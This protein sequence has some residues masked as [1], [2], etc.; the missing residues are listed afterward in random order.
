MD[1][2]GRADRPAALDGDRDIE[3]ERAVIIEEIRSYLD[4]P[5]EYC[6][7]LSRRRCSATG[8]S[9]AR[10]AATRRASGRCPST[11][12]RDFWRTM[13]RP[14]N[15]VVAVAGD[16]GHDEAVE[17]ATAAFGSGNG[18]VP[19]SRPRPALPAGPRCSAR[20]ARHDARPSCA[21][22]CR[23][24]AAT[25]RTAGPSRCSTRSSATG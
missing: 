10:S 11:T 20:Q 19:G 15:T 16:L 6:Q 21:S 3:S 12:I 17:L 22:A 25:I 1:V 7:M 9:G 2:L 24:S 5:A 18:V 13:Y 14:A 8:R 23:R 4:D